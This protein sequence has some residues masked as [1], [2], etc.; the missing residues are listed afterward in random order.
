MEGSGQELVN[1]YQE[2][3]ARK[4]EQLIRGEDNRH[5]TTERLFGAEKRAYVVKNE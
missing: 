3:I 4:D 1:M 2:K 5:W